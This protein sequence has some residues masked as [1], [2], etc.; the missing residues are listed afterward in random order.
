MT[1]HA[2]VK[3]LI[4]VSRFGFTLLVLCNMHRGSFFRNFCAL[5]ISVFY[6]K[7]STIF[8]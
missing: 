6:N 4:F 5:A 2:V 3:S 1:S 7:L 8:Y